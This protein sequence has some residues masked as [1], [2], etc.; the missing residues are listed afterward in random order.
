MKTPGVR[1]P[2]SPAAGH[3]PSRFSFRDRGAGPGSSPTPGDGP[4][5][6]REYGAGGLR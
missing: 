2:I 1:T 4:P 3:S 5:G 6:A